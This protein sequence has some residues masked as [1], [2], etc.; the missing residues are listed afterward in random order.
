[1]SGVISH[2]DVRLTVRHFFNS[3]KARD[4]KGMLEHSQI[5]WRDKPD[6][7]ELKMAIW[8]GQKKLKAFEILVAHRVSETTY[9]VGLRLSYR[10][11]GRQYVKTNVIARVICESAAYSPHPLGTW[12]VN[13]VSVLKEDSF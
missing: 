1:V 5:T 2:E 6:N 12:G 3:W 8:F 7:S 9:D 4:W 11:P 13:P 10:G